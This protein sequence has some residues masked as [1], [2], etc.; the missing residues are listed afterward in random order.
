MTKRIMSELLNGLKQPSNLISL[1]YKG[2]PVVGLANFPILK[3]FY[4]NTSFNDS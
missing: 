2:N 4:F 3:K 1:N